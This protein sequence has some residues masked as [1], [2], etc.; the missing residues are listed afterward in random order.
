M[1]VSTVKNDPITGAP[2]D[3]YTVTGTLF[4]SPTGGWIGLVEGTCTG[5][6]GGTTRIFQYTCTLDCSMNPDGTRSWFIVVEDYITGD[7]SRVCTAPFSD[8]PVWSLLTGAC[9]PILLSGQTASFLCSDLACVIPNLNIDEFFGDVVFDVL[10][11]E[12]P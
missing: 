8:P 3:C 2:T 9:D 12:D 5:W 11:T 1:T 10:V 6:C 7:A 4:L